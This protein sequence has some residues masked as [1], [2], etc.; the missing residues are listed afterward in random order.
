M[1]ATLDRV[2]R[3]SPAATIETVPLRSAQQTRRLP[4]NISP[5]GAERLGPPD[6]RYRP[7]ERMADRV[8]SR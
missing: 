2:N 4:T 1:P 8:G 7:V 5:A 6:W 3:L